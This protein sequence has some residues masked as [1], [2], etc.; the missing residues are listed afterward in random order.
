MARLAFIRYY[1][2]LEADTGRLAAA[3]PTPTQPQRVV[4]C[5]EWTL[6]QLVGHVG[7]PRADRSVLE[8]E[9]MMGEVELRANRVEARPTGG[10]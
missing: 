1:A 5:P 2:E 10:A 3:V 8:R 6:G 9:G 7:L 4:T